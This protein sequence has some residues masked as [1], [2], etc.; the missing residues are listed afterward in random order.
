M[1]SAEIKQAG[2]AALRAAGVHMVVEQMRPAV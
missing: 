2:I 1:T